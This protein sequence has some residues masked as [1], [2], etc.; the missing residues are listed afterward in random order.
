MEMTSK[1]LR[2][3]TSPEERRQIVELYTKEGFSFK[4]IAEKVKRNFVTIR[5]I[6]LEENVEIRSGLREPL[7]EDRKTAM[8]TAY[9]SGL[10]AKQ[11]ATEFGCHACTVRSV[12]KER[13]IQPRSYV[14]IQAALHVG[15]GF[16]HISKHEMHRKEESAGVKGIHWAITAMD[17]ERLYQEQGGK[18]YYSGITMDYANTKG[19]YEKI[20]KGN[21]LAMSIDRRDSSIGYTP[22]NIALCCRFINYAKNSYSETQFK[23][24]LAKTVQSLTLSLD[25]K[26]ESATVDFNP[27]EF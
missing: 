23:G 13:G 4:K 16:S 6:L 2:S 3:C 27:W 11:V 10:N 14:E 7:S 15:D 12:I 22:E 18:C 26:P 25:L 20:M 24:L 5:R 9:Q 1:T 17:I 21:P 19:G 8:V